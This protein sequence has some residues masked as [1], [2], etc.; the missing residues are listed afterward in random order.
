M[1]TC[2]I[3]LGIA[4]LLSAQIGALGQDTTA[5]TTAQRPD[6]SPTQRE[7]LRK[8]TALFI[9]MAILLL[10]ALLAIV[11]ATVTLRRR[12]A[13]LEKRA[14]PAP[15]DSESLWWGTGGAGGG[16]DKDRKE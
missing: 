5:A 8:G 12:V 3:V 11:I 6:L 1:R 16:G 9:V 7:A 15:T 2:V 13:A 10:L 14:R 4:V